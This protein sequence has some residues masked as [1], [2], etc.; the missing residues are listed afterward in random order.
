MVGSAFNR[1]LYQFAESVFQRL[2]A[3]YYIPNSFTGMRVPRA[4]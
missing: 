4:A 2:A 3:G 1:M